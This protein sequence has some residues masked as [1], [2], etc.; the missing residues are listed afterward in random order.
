[1]ELYFLRHAKA[2]PRT[3]RL[4][5]RD[6]ERALTPDGEEKMRLIAMGLQTL[7]LRFD[8]VLSSPY[9]RARQTADIAAKALKCTSKLSLTE[10]LAPAGDPKGLIAEIIR[11][12][13]SLGSVLLVGHEPYLSE[14]ISKLTTGTTHLRLDMKK[15]GLVKLSTDALR[16]GQCATLE[17]LLPPRHLVLLSKV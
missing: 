9:V 10:Q 5:H 2:V 16:Y 7:D 6:A 12:S 13:P 8:R 3:G 17:W 1:M 11:P 15:A 14:L 4:A